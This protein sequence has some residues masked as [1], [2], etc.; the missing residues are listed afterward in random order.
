MYRGERLNSITHLVGSAAALVASIVLITLTAGTGVLRVIAFSVYG[1]TLV[2][3]Y[4]AST[5]Y[6]SLQG[7]AKKIFQRIDHIG[8]YLLI[9]GTYTPF[10]IVMLGGAWGWSLFGVVW[11]MAIIGITCEAVLGDRAGGISSVLYLVMGWIAV[12]AVRP[13]IQA[14]DVSTLA[15]IAAGGLLYTSGF[16]IM[17]IKTFRLRHEIWHF[18]V[19]GGSTCHFVAMLLFIR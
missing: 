4:L 11:T 12:V 13:M 3:L 10:A 6:H 2:F 9:A 17:A 19:L 18:F 1:F 16:G 7:R 15:W 8:I 14:L 5:L